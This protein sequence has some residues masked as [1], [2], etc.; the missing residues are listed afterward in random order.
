MVGNVQWL[1][2]YFV[3]VEQIE[4]FDRTF[5][6]FDFDLESFNLNRFTAA[7]LFAYELKTNIAGTVSC[8]R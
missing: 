5:A 3:A 8:L 6:H 1:T 4:Q 2:Q 7:R